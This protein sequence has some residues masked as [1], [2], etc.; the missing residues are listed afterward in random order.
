MREEKICRRFGQSFHDR[1]HSAPWR[2]RGGN[3][4][5]NVDSKSRLAC[6]DILGEK[7]DNREKPKRSLSDLIEETLSERAD[8]DFLTLSI[9]VGF[10]KTTKFVEVGN[11]SASMLSELTEMVKAG[12]EPLG[13]IG[14]VQHKEQRSTSIYY[15][16]FQEYSGEEWI[17][18]Y[19]DEL[20]ENFRRSA[21][22]KG[23]RVV[24]SGDP[25]K[26]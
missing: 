25:Q 4:S 22:S 17:E 21:I 8:K 13:L 19:F 6:T 7:M 1:K 20:L 10:K 15:R 14:A 9:V 18:P 5:A 24:P 2:Q 12:G 3:V 16:V 26:N 11:D 23:L